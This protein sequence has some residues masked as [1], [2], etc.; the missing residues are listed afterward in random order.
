M[1]DDDEGIRTLLQQQLSG[2][3]YRV[4]VAKDGHDALMRLT[5]ATYRLI[6]TDYHMPRLDGPGLIERAR[7]TVPNLP[8]VLM[9]G[10][11]YN[12]QHCN[13]VPVIE[14]PFQLTDL[15]RILRHCLR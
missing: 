12:A 10:S 3:G 9:T 8:C 15:D 1:V 11:R 6:L 13:G 14:K 7:E 4:D 2:F 5:N